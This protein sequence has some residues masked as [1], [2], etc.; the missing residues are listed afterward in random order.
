M[1]FFERETIFTLRAVIQVVIDE[2]SA[3]SNIFQIH[4]T[5]LHILFFFSTNTSAYKVLLAIVHNLK[6]KKI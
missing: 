5:Q 1:F 2:Y 6:S 3:K 4:M